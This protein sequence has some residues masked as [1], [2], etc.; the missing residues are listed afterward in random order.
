MVRSQWDAP[1]AKLASLHTVLALAARL[2]LNLHQIDIKEAHLNREF[3]DEERIYMRQLPGYLYP[4]AT[5]RVLRLR[6]TIYGLKQSGRH[7]Y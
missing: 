5:G 2:D 1:V 6:K 7:W 3:T 4:N